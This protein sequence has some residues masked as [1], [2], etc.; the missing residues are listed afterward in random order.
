MHLLLEWSRDEFLIHFV[1]PLHGSK[2][3]GISRSILEVQ[4]ETLVLY[5]IPLTGEKV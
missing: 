1:L 3:I 5:L 4:A 2:R